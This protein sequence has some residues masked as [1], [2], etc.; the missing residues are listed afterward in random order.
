MVLLVHTDHNV[1]QEQLGTLLHI[2]IILVPTLFITLQSHTKDLHGVSN[3]KEAGAEAVAGAQGAVASV[4]AGVEADQGAETGGALA[5]NIHIAGE[6]QAS[7]GAGAE[8]GHGAG[9]GRANVH[10]AGVSLRDIDTVFLM[11]TEATL[12][13]QRDRECPQPDNQCLLK[14]VHPRDKL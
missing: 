1:L 2:Q 7:I 9:T 13:T 8:A 6:V 11:K 10:I 5:A 12:F 3:L 14:D 4:G